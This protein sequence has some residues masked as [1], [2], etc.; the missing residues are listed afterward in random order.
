MEGVMK[1]KFEGKL[2]QWQLAQAVAEKAQMVVVN[3][4]A[5]HSVLV[6]ASLELIQDEKFPGDKDKWRWRITGLNFGQEPIEILE[7]P[8]GHI[9]I[10]DGME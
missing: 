9:I 6:I 7:G 10:Q 1:Q 5:V 4:G 8:G 2:D 3:D